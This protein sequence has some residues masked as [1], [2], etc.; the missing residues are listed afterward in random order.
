MNKVCSLEQAL[1][2]VNPGDMVMVGGF[3]V[4]GTPFTLLDGLLKGGVNELTVVKNEANEDHMGI[5]KLVE[6]G[7]V[8]KMITTHLGLNKTVIGMMNRGEVEVEFYPQGI[9]AEKIRAGGAGLFGLLTDIGMDTEL[10]SSTKQTMWFEGRELIVESALKGDVALLHAAKADRFGNLVYAKSAKNFNPVMA[11]AATTVIA[12][13]EEL[14]EIGE[15]DP[16]HVHT[17]G[18]FVDHVV[19]LEELSK[20]YGILEHHII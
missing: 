12:E 16:E 17:P 5:S 18:A 10:L 2:R 3:G 6:A 1:G 4:P 15:L 19:L 20:E 14:V 11:T 8:R 7:L 9:L 13:V